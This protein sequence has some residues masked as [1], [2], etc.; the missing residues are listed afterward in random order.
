MIGVDIAPA[1]RVA[2]MTQVA[3]AGA[4]FS[5]TGRS[6]MTGTSRVCITATVMP[7]NARTGTTPRVLRS[8]GSGVRAPAC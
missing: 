3:L 2:V 4:V 7:A 1:S 8:R 5:S 6:L